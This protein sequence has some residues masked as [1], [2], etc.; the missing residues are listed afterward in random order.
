MWCLLWSDVH[1]TISDY[2]NYQLIL[3]CLLWLDVHLTI[4]FL[5]NSLVF[6]VIR[7]SSDYY[8]LL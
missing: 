4:I 1:L 6:T 2:Y 5:D 3:S 7:C 8:W